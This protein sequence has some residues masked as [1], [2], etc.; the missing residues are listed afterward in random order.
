M[1]QHDQQLLSA[2]SSAHPSTAS[3]VKA[4]LLATIYLLAAILY[5]SITYKHLPE[6][7]LS[8]W[9]HILHSTPWQLAEVFIDFISHLF[10]ALFLWFLEGPSFLWIPCKLF[11]VLTIP[12]GNFIMLLY[13]AYVLFI[14]RSIVGAL[15]PCSSQ[16][17]DRPV[18]SP[19]ASRTQSQVVGIVAFVLC[20]LFVLLLLRSIGREGWVT[21]RDVRGDDVAKAAVLDD[22]VSL[23]LPVVWVFVRESGHGW[24]A[25]GW[26]VA[27][28][29]FDYGAVCLYVVLVAWKS[30][31]TDTELR[32]LLLSKRRRGFGG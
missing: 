25:L 1:P 15:L 6:L 32:Y 3:T 26:V 29:L 30:V 31:R 20:A 23:V 2:S 5:L 7:W 17:E 13:I 10:S 9:F 14:K 18:F 11:A 19:A 28:L 24:V 27:V 22:V 8:S 4:W 12:L 21:R 16:D